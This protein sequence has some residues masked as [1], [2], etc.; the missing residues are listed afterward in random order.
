MGTHNKLYEK[1]MDECQKKIGRTEMDDVRNGM[2]KERCK[3]NYFQD[4]ISNIAKS[5]DGVKI[6]TNNVRDKFCADIE[7][8]DIT[9]KSVEKLIETQ[10]S[11]IAENSTAL[12]GI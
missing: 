8:H 6:E 12:K 11:Q 4:K 5:V 7:G 2:E 1:V 10:T 9:L 3:I